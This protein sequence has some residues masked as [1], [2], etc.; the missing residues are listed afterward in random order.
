MIF[1]FQIAVVAAGREGFRSGLDKDVELQM[2]LA[3]VPYCTWAH[4]VVPDTVTS[5][6]LDWL[7]AG[8][9]S[10]ENRQVNLANSVQATELGPVVGPAGLAE[11]QQEHRGPGVPL[12]P[13]NDDASC[14]ASW[15]QKGE[16]RIAVTPG[17][18]AEWK[19]IIM[20]NIVQHRGVFGGGPPT[21]V[22]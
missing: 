19:A 20:L 8:G 5:W 14:V 16:L 10:K 6:R 17:P 9:D 15:A 18:V 22:G 21:E 3:R 2:S 12:S 4:V 1:F 11:F 13:H 7:W